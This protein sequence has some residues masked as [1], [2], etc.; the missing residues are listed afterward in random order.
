[1]WE[2]LLELHRASPWLSKNM[3]SESSPGHLLTNVAQQRSLPKFTLFFCVSKSPSA[4]NVEQKLRPEPR[5]SGRGQHFGQAL[6]GGG[7]D[8]A[9]I[10]W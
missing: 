7:E 3:D 10:L 9:G 5:Y 4:K 1:M 2:K 6:D 8:E